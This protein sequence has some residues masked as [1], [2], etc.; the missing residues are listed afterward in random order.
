MQVRNQYAVQCCTVC[1]LALGCLN[2]VA[3][4]EIR[5]WSSSSGTHNIE[6]ELVSTSSTSVIL[7][8]A[9][10][11]E[12]TIPVAKLCQADR[13]FIASLDAHAGQNDEEAIKST[14]NGFYRAVRND[15]DGIREYL[16]EKGR[17]NFDNQREYF[18]MGAPAPGQRPRVTGIR[19]VTDSEAIAD[20]RLKLG[21]DLQRMQMLFAKE[22][23]EWRVYG[24]AGLGKTTKT[25]MNF[26]KAESTQES[27]D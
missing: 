13:D 15:F 27:L 14:V 2:S 17:G 9:E 12:V 1:I 21:G 7:R 16:T 5:K 4:G 18:K 25:V 19:I 3:L 10:G 23:N 24:L 22:H 8:T 26:E 11:R 20:F 6:A